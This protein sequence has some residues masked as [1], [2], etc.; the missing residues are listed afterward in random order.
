MLKSTKTI[1]F[2]SRSDILDFAK[3]V[4]WDVIEIV[5]LE[6]LKSGSDRLTSLMVSMRVM[7][8]SHA[9]KHSITQLPSSVKVWI[10]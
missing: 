4:T 10:V 8:N 7:R 9:G 5:A 3:S 6:V 2:L 1:E